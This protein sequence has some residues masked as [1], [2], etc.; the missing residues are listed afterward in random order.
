MGVIR[1]VGRMV[2]LPVPV[3]PTKGEDDVCGLGHEVFGS[4][5]TLV[6]WFRECMFHREAV[7]RGEPAR[8]VL[9]DHAQMERVSVAID[10]E[11]AWE[12]RVGSSKLRTMREANQTKKRELRH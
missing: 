4:A 12:E 11:T 10:Q 1:Y 2:R 8:F 7:S 3:G 9:P 5:S 6:V